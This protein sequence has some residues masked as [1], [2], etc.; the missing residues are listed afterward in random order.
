[1]GV[2]TP[3]ASC[4]NSVCRRRGE[5]QLPHERE[6]AL[7]YKRAIVSKRRKYCFSLRD[8]MRVEFSSERTRTRRDFGR[9][10]AV[11]VVR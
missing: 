3:V 4:R 6:Q 11:R 5:P 7:V 1:V 9:R 10:S 2:N 8:A